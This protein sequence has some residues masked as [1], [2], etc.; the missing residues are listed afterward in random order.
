MKVK[1]QKY[2]FPRKLLRTQTTYA[3]QTISL[4]MRA[5]TPRRHL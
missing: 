5:R 1:M 3:Y 2:T 4:T